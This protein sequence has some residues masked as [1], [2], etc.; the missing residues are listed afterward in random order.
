MNISYSFGMVDLLHYGH[1]AALKKASESADLRIFGLVSDASSDA[2]FGTHV[3]NE[4]ERRAVVEGIKYIDEVW[5]QVTFDPIDNLRALH[6]KYPTAVISLFTGNEWGVI[7]A[8]KY[9]ESIGGRVVKLDYY[10]K[11]SPKAILEKLNESMA[12]G[13]R[14]N[15]MISTKANTLL[16]LKPVVTK[17]VIEEAYVV[18]H[19]DYLR[20][21]D[22]VASDI[23]ELFGNNMIVVRSSSK[24]ED[25]YEESNAGHFISLLDVDADDAEE[26]K[27]AIDSVY[28]S[29]GSECDEDEQVLVQRQ[30][31]DV[32][33]SGVVF[34]RDI[35]RNR[36]YYVVSYDESGDTA[37]VTSGQNCKQAWIAND[38]DKENIPDKWKGLM[39]TVW[40]LED[41]LPGILLDIEFAITPKHV[42]IFQVRPLAAAIKFGRNNEDLLVNDSRD[43][44]KKTYRKLSKDGMSCFSD[45]A[46]W[47]PAEIIG[48][49]PYNL[50]YSLY[51]E[52]ITKS[53]WD[54][55]LVPMGYR[56]VHKE[57][58][59][60]FGNKPYISVELSLEA[61][62]PAAITDKMSREL[63]DFYV[64]KLKKNLSAHDKIEFEI[65]HNCFDFTLHER[66]EELL[67]N[68]FSDSDVESFEK[69]LIILT[70]KT[71]NSYNDVL[72]EDLSDLNRLEGVR[73]DVQNI[74]NG[75]DD[76][77]QIVKSIKVLVDAIVNYG[78]VQFSR[79]A[80][81][82]FMA[83][84]L[85]KTLAEKNYVG[86]QVFND[87]MSSIETVAVDYDRDY[88][89]VNEGKMSRQEFLL[90]YGHLRSGTYNIRNLRY[91]QRKDLFEGAVTNSH[92]RDD[93]DIDKPNALD[94]IVENAFDKAF[95]DYE[96]DSLEGARTIEFIRQSTSQREYFKF[97][98][99]KS[100]SAVLEMVKKLGHLVSI[101]ADDLSF[102]EL[103]E[104]Y[105]TEFYS[106][107][108]MVRD[109][110]NMIIS[111][112][113]D[114]HRINSQLI[115]P[116]VICTIDDFECIENIVTRPNY[117][118]EQCI[119]GE[120]VALDKDRSNDL[121]GKIVVIEKADPGYDWIFSK[122]I[123]G[124]ITKYGGAASHMAIRCAEFSVPAAIGT[125]NVLFEFATGCNTII[126]DCKNGK[127]SKVN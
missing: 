89:A 17:A 16:A 39:E 20:D 7:S 95:H 62:L 19:A 126:I 34:T 75:C 104:V 43:S 100:L 26:V 53:A 99:T 88:R 111:K 83:K 4:E 94:E 24:R 81:C 28:D 123:A 31:K 120:V 37:S 8:R 101:E 35:Q 61:L 110:W 23:R 115:L 116:E 12:S 77:G 125:G 59:Y 91:D 51:R 38:A 80:R 56:P 119:T 86:S 76:I 79:Q 25:A 6:A 55:G 49:N 48:E 63:V 58:M 117:I 44:A 14:T 87:F 102:L 82:A 1:M 27:S 18:S 70:R 3:S 71:I 36:P 10:D 40:E 54:K 127:I 92:D 107:P 106:S 85:I 124:L 46:F 64:K 30:T 67:Q 74:T 32:V 47:N 13:N 113:K 72:T 66:L 50:D 109:F 52:I 57:L 11:L 45:M 15:S 112:R 9:V 41:L 69:A 65:S 93:H 42:V 60:R 90:K 29:Y 98:F 103:A 96:I 73:L 84:S 97:V 114:Y 121:D 108:C 118:T 122:G 33:I 105:A 5:P 68:G 22:K 2:W 78:T 21:K